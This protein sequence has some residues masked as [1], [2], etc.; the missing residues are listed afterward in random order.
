MSHLPSGNYVI[1]NAGTEKAVGAIEVPKLLGTLAIQSTEDASVRPN[2]TVCTIR[3]YPHASW[4]PDTRNSLHPCITQFKLTHAKE[5]NYTVEVKGLPVVAINGEVV[6]LVNPTVHVEWQI[7][8][9]HNI[10]GT[11]QAFAIK[12]LRPVPKG[13]VGITGYGWALEKPDA[14]TDVTIEGLMLTGPPLF[15][16]PLQAWVFQSV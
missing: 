5:N 13:L 2:T 14:G 12:Q 4:A 10:P 3:C 7:T 6:A 8:P 1:I 9:L 16:D 11:R 15:F